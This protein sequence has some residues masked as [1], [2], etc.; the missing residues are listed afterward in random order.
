MELVAEIGQNHNGD[1]GLA[2]ELIHSARENGADVVKFQIYDARM[3]FPKDGNPWYDYNCATELSRE[4]VG[5]LY[6]ECSRVGI[7]FIASAFDEERVGWLEELGVKRH[8]IA[9]RSIGDLALIQR[10][11]ITG[12]PLLV[13]LGMWKGKEFPVLNTTASI[14]FLYCVSE[15]PTPLEMVKLGGIDFSRYAGFSDHT[16]GISSAMAALARGAGIIEKHFTMDKKMYGPD[17]AGSMTPSELRNLHNF[18][19]DLARLL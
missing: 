5:R 4:Q 2:L 6:E 10:L 15:Y 14:L 12:K 19:S 17:H 7:E 13:S 9:S 18:R 16:E 3:L 11:C 8:K 1:T